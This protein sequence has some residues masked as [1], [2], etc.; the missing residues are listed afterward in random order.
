MKEMT[1][2]LTMNRL[3][4]P[5]VN[6]TML[7]IVLENGLPVY[8][9]PKKGFEQKYAIFATNYGSIDDTFRLHGN[10]EIVK[11]PDGIAHFLEHKMF[12]NE[13]GNTFDKFA[14]LG[15]NVNAFTTYTTTSYLFDTIENFDEC[16]DLLLDFV[17]SLYL[18]DESVEKEKGIIA[19]E[20]AMYDDDPDWVCYLNL[21]R[22]LFH[23]HLVR[24]DIAGTAASIYQIDRTALNRCYETFY[25]P[26]NMALFLQGDFDLE[27]VM[28]RIQANQAKKDYT[29]QPPI[30]R[31]YPEE[32]PTVARRRIETAM[33]VSRPIYNLGFKERRLGKRGDELLKQ[34]LMTSMLLEMLVGKGSELYQEMYESGLIDDSFAV[35]YTGEWDHGMTVI[36]GH[37]KDPGRL[38][39]VLMRG[40]D[41]RKGH[42][43]P[44]SM[45]RIRKR[46]IGDYIV[47]FDSLKA[48]AQNFISYFFRDMNLFHELKLLH[49]ITLADLEER[50]R[51]HFDEHYHAVSIIQ[52]AE[53]ENG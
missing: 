15:A 35:S 36:G 17:Q 10:G 26:S 52:P 33:S 46:M 22:C 51:E 42:L 2:K 39:E 16:L 40:I 5:E 19:Q 3:H 30:E 47:A 41:A 48:T 23:Q 25:H 12:E 31:F 32:P 8:I 49:A 13:D 37:T 1:M 9:L 45:E 18:T 14:A 7:H 38:H 29:P 11:V 4:I 53:A 20:I 44:E 27:Q 24:V 6:E 21:M 34:D 50:L 28:E 43:Q